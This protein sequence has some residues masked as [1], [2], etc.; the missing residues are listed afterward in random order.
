MDQAGGSGTGRQTSTGHFVTV[1]GVRLHYGSAGAGL[2]AVLLHGNAGFTHDYAA[3]TDAL[4]ARG[5]QALAFDRPGHGHSTRP[6]GAAAT[7]QAQAR[8]LHEALAA[9]GIARPIIVGHSWSGALALAYALAHEQACAALVLLAP[10][11][12]PEPPA[13][14][15]EHALLGIPVLSDLF[16]K[17]SAARI[18]REI[19]HSLQRAFAPDPVPADYLHIAQ[20]LWQ[21]ASQIKA[22]VQDELTYA[23]DTQALSAHYQTVRAPVII[24]TGDADQLVAPTRHAYPLSRAL[25]QA[26]LI[27]LPATGHMLPHTR[28]QEVLAAIEAA[29][30]R[31]LYAR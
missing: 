1:A 4:P 25:T 8:L 5:F 30:A 29:H 28:T 19:E 16:I 17:L 14:G 6:N 23:A 15:A 2:P 24:M 7:I 3:L 10:A 22:T 9:L 11:V 20:A 12:Y 18:A 21:R 31:S 27:V 13:Y 26:E